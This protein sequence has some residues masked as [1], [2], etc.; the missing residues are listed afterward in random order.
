MCNVDTAVLGQVWHDKKDPSA[1]PDFNT[2][3]TCKNYDDVREWAKRLQVRT[4]PPELCYNILIN[5]LFQ[6]PPAE[7]MPGDFLGIPKPEDIL[8]YTP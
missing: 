2:K 5:L 7:T 1:F 4:F 6:A 8:E 3:H